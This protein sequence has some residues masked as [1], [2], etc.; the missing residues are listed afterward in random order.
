MNRSFLNLLGVTSLAMA[1]LNPAH[2]APA[3]FSASGAD[4]TSVFNSFRTAIG[5]GSRIAWDGVRLDGTDVN[6]NTRVIDPGKTVEIPVDRFRA[7]GAIYADPYTV[8]GDGFASV[9]P[10][11]AGQF[12]AFTPRNTFAMFDTQPGSFEDRFI[13]QTFVLPGTNTEAATRG[14]GA[15]FLDNETAGASKI[16]YFGRD[17]KGQSVSLGTY[18]VPVGKDGE[19]Q[20]LGVL[21][22]KPIITE[23]KLTVGTY[24][25]FNFD[26]KTLQAFGAEN[27]PHGI[28]LAVTDDFVFA[29]P[30]AIQP[31]PIPGAV[32]LLTSALPVLL[33]R[34]LSARDA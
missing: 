7:V 8:S 33:R 19:A 22:D 5:G 34:R 21:F 12:N 23:V 2:A 20:F 17:A 6:P 1:S 14:F 13:E 24:A 9:N 28:D 18:D 30:T 15:I 11:S 4:T 29:T 31:V 16:E 3:I 27:L 32:W 26:G 25:L 10:G